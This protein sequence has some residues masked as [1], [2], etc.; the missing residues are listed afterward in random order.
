MAT[1]E[2]V[3]ALVAELPATEEGTAYGQRAWK[4]Q[5][6]TLLVWERPLRRGDLDALGPEAPTGDIVGLRTEG[7]AEK[8]ELIAA[9]P[10]VF[11]TTPH[12][13]GHP[14]VLA[15]LEALPVDVLRQ[16]V[17]AEWLRSAPKRVVAAY[18]ADGG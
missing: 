10:E 14:A 8:E 3:A 1:W 16:L 9:F 5:R 13:Q 17:R 11:F 4:I 7:A 18:R 15:R 12:F 6:R 2:D